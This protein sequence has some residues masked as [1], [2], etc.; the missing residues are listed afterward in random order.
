MI[1]QNHHEIY[2]DGEHVETLF[3]KLRK[4]E[5]RIITLIKRWCRKNVSIQFI[6]LLSY[7]ADRLELDRNI[8]K[9]DLDV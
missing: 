4:S 3:V 6:R 1:V 2:G 5:H 8:N 7:T 9:V